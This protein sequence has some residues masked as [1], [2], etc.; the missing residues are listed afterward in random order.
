MDGCMVRGRLAPSVHTCS[1]LASP[2]YPSYLSSSFC[3]ACLLSGCSERASAAKR[4]KAVAVAVSS[5]LT[6]AGWM[7]ADGWRSRGSC[8]ASFVCSV[9]FLLSF[10]FFF[11]FFCCSSSYFFLACL[12]SGYL[13]RA[14]TAKRKETVAA[15]VVFP[16]SPMVGWMV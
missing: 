11:S 14:S 16:S 2:T 3:L 4:R 12:I 9:F 8:Y 5:P 6:M 13:T 15:R 10:F 7:A 1:S